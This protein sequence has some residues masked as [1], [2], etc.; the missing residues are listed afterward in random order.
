[1]APV[2]PANNT[3]KSRVN[4]DGADVYAFDDDS[5]ASPE[6]RLDFRQNPRKSKPAEDGGEQQYKYFD[7]PQDSSRVIQL[8]SVKV[9][10]LLQLLGYSIKLILHYVT[11]YGN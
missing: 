7:L 8:A 6:P 2:I 1:M 9:Y 4:G 10:Y 11:V 3:P 5:S